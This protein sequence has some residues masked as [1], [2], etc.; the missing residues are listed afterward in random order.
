MALDET[1]PN[2]RRIQLDGEACPLVADHGERPEEFS[3]F[4][5]RWGVLTDGD[6]GKLPFLDQPAL[7]GLLAGMRHRGP[8]GG[9]ESVFDGPPELVAEQ[10]AM[11]VG[12]GMGQGLV[13]LGRPRRPG[14]L[15]RALRGVVPPLLGPRR[16]RAFTGRHVPCGDVLRDVLGVAAHA[17]HDGRA[18][19]G[20][21][22]Q[23]DGVQARVFG[24]AAVVPGV[25]PLV[26]HRDVQDAEV[27][28]VARGPED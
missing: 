28:P 15:R 16:S 4:T 23:P 8:P 3:L 2:Y 19:P 5:S 10:L 18:V 17:R 20:Q 14:G 7:F 25:V 11:P 21:P 24:D 22:R 1:E 27:Q 6:G 13:Q 12:P 26:Q 9:G